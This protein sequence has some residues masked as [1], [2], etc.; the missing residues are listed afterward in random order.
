MGKVE[1]LMTLDTA[2]KKLVAGMMFVIVFLASG[3]G[4]TVY[5]YG[6]YRDKKEDQISKMERQHSIETIAF[7][8]RIIE[9][10]TARQDRLDS[11]LRQVKTLLEKTK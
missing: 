3:W 10:Q 1:Y 5:R 2:E 6:N 9:G 8:N 7:Y 11:A 4:I